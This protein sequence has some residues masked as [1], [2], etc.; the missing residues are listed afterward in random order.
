MATTE[1]SK[2]SSKYCLLIQ[3]GEALVV[4]TE[5]VYLKN[6]WYAF[7]EKHTLYINNNEALYLEVTVLSETNQNLAQITVFF[8]NFVVIPSYRKTNVI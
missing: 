2:S 4:Y 8:C 7:L 1:E 5:I 3:I 6:Q